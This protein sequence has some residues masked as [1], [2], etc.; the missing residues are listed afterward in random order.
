MNVALSIK[1]TEVLVS[2]FGPIKIASK[3]QKHNI[4]IIIFL[5]LRPVTHGK[6]DIN[7]RGLSHDI[8]HHT[9]VAD[10]CI[11]RMGVI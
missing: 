9:I 11:I 2:L 5:V 8:A 7:G 10:R 3:C 6:Y 4:H 1:R